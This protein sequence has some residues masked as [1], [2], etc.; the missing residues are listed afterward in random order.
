MA[1]QR[2]I[3]G[4]STG[5]EQLDEVIAKC[6]ELSRKYS[7][8][9][10]L[11]YVREERL[12]DLPIFGNST[13]RSMESLHDRLLEHLRERGCE[14][15]AVLAYDNDPVDR[16]KLEA[17]REGSFLLVSDDHDETDEMVEKIPTR[18]LILKKGLPHRY[19]CV[20]LALDSAY[21]SDEGLDEVL[22]FA[23]GAEVSCYMDYQL[24]VSTSD[25]SLDPVVGAM[26]P[27]VLM[28]EES[29]VID[30][31]K[32]AFEQLCKAKGLKGHFELGEHGLVDDILDRS[33]EAE[34]DL[35]AL[36]TEDRDTLMAEAAKE[37]APRAKVDILIVYNH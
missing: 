32:N 2:R 11:L 21:G 8:G 18:T 23:A 3:L 9:V 6:A 36:V 26:T 31:R 27:D 22:D 28:A 37:I 16:A 15:W 5:P 13:E 17:E 29:E 12:F 19:E 33:R 1:K 24:I 7:A 25:P 4:L 34:P 14:E 20:F 30:I 35:L 10:T